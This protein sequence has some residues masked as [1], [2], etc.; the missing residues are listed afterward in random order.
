MRRGGSTATRDAGIRAPDNEQAQKQARKECTVADW[1]DLQ[2]ADDQTAAIDALM[3]AGMDVD[4]AEQRLR[5]SLPH[6]PAE[7][8]RRL[9]QQVYRT[10]ALSRAHA[11]LDDDAFFRT[12]FAPPDSNPEVLAAEAW[13]AM[14]AAGIAAA[15][16]GFGSDDASDSLVAR[17]LARID[18][19]ER[20]RVVPLP[21]RSNAVGQSASSRPDGPAMLPSLALP[22][23]E[24]EV[25][26]RRGKAVGSGFGWREGLVAA[27]AV[28]I[29]ASVA[30]PMIQRGRAYGER[31]ACQGHMGRLAQSFDG[32][33]SDRNGA[34]PMVRAAANGD[35]W[36]N[37]RPASANLLTLA[38]LGYTDPV[39]LSC[40][41]NR[42]AYVGKDLLQMDNWPS[43]EATS[44]SYQHLVGPDLPT[45]GGGP[46]RMAL[47]GDRS[48][49][50]SR[51]LKHEPISPADRSPSHGP[52]GQNV[53][54]SD[55]S[56]EWLQE[57]A[58]GP[59]HIWLPG[60]IQICD[61]LVVKG[62]E[63]P[64]GPYDSMLVH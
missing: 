9:L 16:D 23:A 52:D 20:E 62:T 4:E 40:P 8:V 63:A 13:L 32:Y 48:P 33:A 25:E 17:T 29:V 34:L 39:T 50:I 55:G 12:A 30:L 21:T 5:A 58:I 46:H 59:D 56:T 60:T 1:T 28:M 31:M 47:L 27:A 26:R 6:L 49:V 2:L 35:D 54:F 10:F 45:W 57:S 44:F 36:L 22:A 51:A 42:D 7:A 11:P 43:L 3:E 61:P 37:A 24:V 14:D 19:V 15:G 18:S 64:A 53:M 38:K 41:S